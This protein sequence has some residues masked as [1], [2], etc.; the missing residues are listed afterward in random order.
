MDWQ[1]HYRRGDRQ[2]RAP[3]ADR[4][5]AVAVACIFLRDGHDVTKLESLA[6]E[7]ID[8]AELKRLCGCG[9]SCSG[10]VCQADRL[11]RSNS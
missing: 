5:T 2:F 1:V 6:D 8:A 10:S 7:T 9:R 4:S 11:W 3:A